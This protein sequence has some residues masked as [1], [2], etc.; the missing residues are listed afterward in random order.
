M[1]VYL[2]SFKSKIYVMVLNGLETVFYKII[3]DVDFRKIKFKYGVIDNDGFWKFTFKK[4]NKGCYIVLGFDQEFKLI[5]A[6][7]LFVENVKNMSIRNFK[8]SL[9]KY[10]DCELKI[11]NVDKR[12]EKLLKNILKK[13]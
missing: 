12:E 5:R 3:E 1:R 7:K 8:Y 11:E 10:K 2:L 4:N 13:L 6:W 9:D